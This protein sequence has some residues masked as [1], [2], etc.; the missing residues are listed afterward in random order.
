METRPS[1]TRGFIHFFQDIDAAGV[2]RIKIA[3]LVVPGLMLATWFA[4]GLWDAA[5]YMTD[6]KILAEGSWAFA[7]NAAMELKE[8]LFALVLLLALCLPIVVFRGDPLQDRDSRFI[9][10]TVSVLIV[11]TGLAWRAQ[12]RS[13]AAA[14]R[15]VLQPSRLYRGQY[16][17][18]PVTTKSTPSKISAICNST[19]IKPAPPAKRCARNHMARVP[20]RQRGAHVRARI[21]S[22]R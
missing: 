2:R 10:S 4:G 21:P 8:H 6:Q 19:Y 16:P 14:D 1:T 15:A 12:A 9:V 5:Y 20:P 7:G 22:S 13:S 3:S 18:I 17:K 11:L